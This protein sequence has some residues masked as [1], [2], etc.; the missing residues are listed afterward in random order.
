MS[1]EEITSIFPLINDARYYIKLSLDKYLIIS[2]DMETIQE[3]V[4]S[5]TY[6]DYDVTQWVEENVIKP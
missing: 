2:K 3:R 6:D 1:T 4:Y 5:Q